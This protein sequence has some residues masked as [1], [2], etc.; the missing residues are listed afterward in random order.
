MK[1]CS[2]CGAELRDRDEFCFKCGAKQEGFGEEPDV[3]VVDGPKE[4]PREQEQPSRTGG[5]NESLVDSLDS[6][7]RIFAII[8]SIILIWTIIVPIF[9]FI[10]ASKIKE[11]MSKDDR[12]L[13]GILDCFFCGLIVGVFL[14]V[15]YVVQDAEEK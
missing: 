9:G 12:L 15:T 14:I 13:W 10:T 1:Y 2:K 5:N 8:F 6:L 11:G 7:A 4:E 3:E